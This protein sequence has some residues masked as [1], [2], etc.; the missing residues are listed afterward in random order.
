MRLVLKWED[1]KGNKYVLGI[2]EKNATKYMFNLNDEGYKEALKNGCAGI[3]ILGKESQE[4]DVLFQFFRERI[5]GKENPRLKL[6]MQRFDLEEYDDMELLRR[7][8]AIVNTDR[9]YLEEKIEK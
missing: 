8:K 3:G 2:L 4:A 1:I 9:F 7:S 6:F 5:P